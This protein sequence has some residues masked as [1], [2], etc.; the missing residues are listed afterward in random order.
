MTFC[1]YYK[2]NKNEELFRKLENSNLNIL[3]LQ[4]YIPIYQNFFSL[5]E[6]NFNSI[7]LNHKYHL[8]SIRNTEYNESRNILDTTI[9]DNSNNF[10][11]SKTFCKFSPL[12]DPLK[13]LTGKYDSSLN[14]ITTLP[15]LNN[16]SDC[17]PKL[18]DKNNN[19][20]V[21]GFFTYLSSQLLHNFNFI[22]GIDYYGSFLGIQNDFMYNI[23]DDFSYLN[24]SEYFHKNIDNKFSI[25][26]TDFE[27]IFN[28]DSRNNKKKLVVNNKLDEISINDLSEIEFDLVAS[29]N[30]NNLILDLSDVCI[31]STTLTH[32]DDSDSSC[33]SNS[34]NTNDNTEEMDYSDT[35]SITISDIFTFEIIIIFVLIILIIFFR[36]FIKK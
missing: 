3:K 18:I 19:S 4:N 16:H 29:N 27:N 34:S 8:H 9:C 21:D 12:L 24:D 25:D 10:T 23:A 13:Y 35:E 5:T 17:I 11:I 20:Y 2:K 28:I 22:H 1:L 7:N 30:E 31:F 6:N 32:H 15:N 14:L 36:I 26:N 33:S